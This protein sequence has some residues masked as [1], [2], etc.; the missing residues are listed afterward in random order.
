MRVHIEQP[1]PR[2]LDAIHAFLTETYWSPG[3][4]RDAVERACAHSVCTI[5][6]DEVGDLIGFARAVTD[7]TTFAWLC[8]VFVLP[9]HRG[10]GLAR[11]LVAALQSELPNL[12]RWMLATLDAHEVYTPLG[13]EPLPAPERYMHIKQDAP[14]GRQT[15]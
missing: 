6:R 10:Q 3:I 11:D 2:D 14:Y 8:D 13:F 7:R 12:R 5:A 1:S 4:A 9:S 15:G